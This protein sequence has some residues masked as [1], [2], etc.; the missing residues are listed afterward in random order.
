VLVVLLV[1]PGLILSGGILAK[2]FADVASPLWLIV[3]VLYTVLGLAG[4]CLLFRKL[5]RMKWA[6]ALFSWLTPR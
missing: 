6:F 3:M 4:A 1:I 2:A 5:P